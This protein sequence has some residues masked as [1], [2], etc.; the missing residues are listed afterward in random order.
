MT[1]RRRDFL[2]GAMAGACM[3]MFL[4]DAALAAQQK[5]EN[6]GTLEGAPPP[7]YLD[8]NTIDFW[9]KTVP[10]GKTRS[11]DAS[12]PPLPDP[13]KIPEFLIYTDDAHGFRSIGEIQDS[14]LLPSGDATVSLFVNQLRCSQDDV[15]KSTNLKAAALRINM[16]Q[17]KPLVPVLGVL[18]YPL[19]AAICKAPR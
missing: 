2:G 10:A 7:D 15:K 9:M 11:A 5:D 12:I 16:Q 17:Q 19:M 3:P 6:L 14:E 8:Q 13:T 1:I 4:S 18:A